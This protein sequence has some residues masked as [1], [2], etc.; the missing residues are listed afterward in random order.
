[1]TVAKA[2]LDACA[3]ATHV[4]CPIALP[5]KEHG[6]W[7]IGQPVEHPGGFWLA[8]RAGWS[9]SEAVARLSPPSLL[10]M[11]SGLPVRCARHGRA[12]PAP[13]GRMDISRSVAS[14]MRSGA[15]WC[16]RL[17]PSGPTAPPI[18]GSQRHQS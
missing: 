15:R 18:G 13:L 4:L 1:M 9:R 7:T 10:A 12:L 11:V 6:W 8:D 3:E 17:F 5:G 16:T 14:W 2:M